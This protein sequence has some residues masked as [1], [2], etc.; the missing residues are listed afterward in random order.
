MTQLKA[1]LLYLGTVWPEPSSSAA[2]VRT[3]ALLDDFLNFGYE[4]IFVSPSKETGFQAALEK[5]GIQTRS[6]Q[7]NDSSFDTFVAELKPEIVVYDRFILE[8]QFGWRVKENSP[9]SLQVLDLQDLHS[10][11]RARM[12]AFVNHTAV[13]LMTDDL[14]R[15]IASI[16]RCDLTLVISPF[17]KSLLETEFQVPAGLLMELGY[18][19]AAPKSDSTSFETRK[20]IAMI[21]NFRHPPNRDALFWLQKEIWPLV[22]KELGNVEVYLYGAYPPKEV[23]AL[24][25]AK[26][27]FRVKG[28]A[29]D[30]IATLSG[31]R[32]SLAP[33]RFG[34]GI[35]GKIADSWSAGTPVVATPVGSEGMECE[36]EFAGVVA[37]DA[38]S[39]GREV[40]ELYR[41]QKKWTRVQ[42]SGRNSLATL[43]GVEKNR[44]ALKSRLEHHLQNRDRLRRENV[45]GL[46]LSHA[47]LRSTKYFSKWIELKE[48]G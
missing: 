21:G 5:K 34:A 13:D 20:H 10:L 25:D 18:S 12:A 22:R 17:E 14:L 43:Y 37:S 23:M 4:I 39:F 15:E 7:P 47:T 3:R 29:D 30:S 8:E 28:Q 44:Q 41:D 11:R 48:K 31:Y 19:Y 36:G 26:S 33:L 42:A 6:F 32:L 40:I 35:K 1:K 2:G 24:D 38:E 27:G 45:V 46:M 16:Y 9:A